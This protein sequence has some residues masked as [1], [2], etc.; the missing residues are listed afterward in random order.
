MT[1][2]H[3]FPDKPSP[4]HTLGRPIHV[5]HQGQQ[6]NEPQATRW[7]NASSIHDPLQSTCVRTPP[8]RTLNL[9]PRYLKSHETLTYIKGTSQESTC[10]KSITFQLLLVIHHWLRR[11]VFSYRNPFTQTRKI[12][13]PTTIIAS[14]RPLSHSQFPPHNTFF[15][16]LIEL[17]R[18]VK[19]IQTYF[20]ACIIES[21][22]SCVWNKISS[23]NNKEERK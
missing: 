2:S 4:H 1:L 6:P 11:L 17:I 21:K 18:L 3:D 12:G 20:Y 5:S 10:N 9:V 16:D 23:W 22:I 15:G 13:A 8:S 7:N 19:F 14:L